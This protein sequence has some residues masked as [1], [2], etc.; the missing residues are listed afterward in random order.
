MRR[1]KKEVV[2]AEPGKHPFFVEGERYGTRTVYG[3]NTTVLLEVLHHNREIKGWYQTVWTGTGYR[4]SGTTQQ[5][6]DSNHH[7]FQNIK[8]ERIK[9]GYD[10]NNNYIL[11]Y[12]ISRPDMDIP[13]ISTYPHE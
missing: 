3:R 8:A 10:V 13:F 1:S 4:P 7:D 9:D 12:G 11:F 2:C 6:I 5:F